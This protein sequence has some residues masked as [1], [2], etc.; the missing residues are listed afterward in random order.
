MLDVAHQLWTLLLCTLLVGNCVHREH[1]YG[2]ENELAAVRVV[3]GWCKGRLCDCL[4]FLTIVGELVEGHLLEIVD[5]N[6]C[7]V[8]EALMSDVE[9]SYIGHHLVDELQVGV[10]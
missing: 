10:G 5:S 6:H 1:Q 2:G 8:S 9:V 4:H 7:Y 3:R